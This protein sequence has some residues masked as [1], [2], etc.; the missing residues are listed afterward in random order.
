MRAAVFTLAFLIGWSPALAQS[1]RPS[2]EL[3]DSNA[4][5]G[6]PYVLCLEKAM[7]ETNREMEALVERIAGLIEMRSDL[8]AAQKNRWKSSLEEAQVL[9]VR[10]RNH[11]CQS[12]APFEGSKPPPPAGGGRI[13]IGSFEERLTCLID[14]NVTRIHEL[15]RRY[16]G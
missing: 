10:F 4:L 3:C 8:A 1:K 15:M 12:V 7:F 5:S 16:T 11:E 14:K 9:F 13:P 2:L 6:R